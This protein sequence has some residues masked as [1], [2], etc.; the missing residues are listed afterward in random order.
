[1]T[2]REF[3]ERTGVE[4]KESEF[5][6]IND[7]YYM[8]DVDKDEFCRLWCKMNPVK[9]ANSKKAAE[10]RQELIRQHATLGDIYARLRST[11]GLE[12]KLRADECEALSRADIEYTYPWGGERIKWDIMEAIH[13]ILFA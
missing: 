11:E 10:K 2:Q 4:V 13:K 1:M 9:V 3:T 12:A 7:V 8:S 6:A 5:E